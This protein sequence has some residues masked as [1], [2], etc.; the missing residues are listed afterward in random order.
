MRRIC[1]KFALLWNF[2]GRSTSNNNNND[3]FTQLFIEELL[4]NAWLRILT[5]LTRITTIYDPQ[6][7]RN[8][9]SGPITRLAHIQDAFWTE[10]ITYFLVDNSMYYLL[11]VWSHTLLLRLM[12][13]WASC[14]E[15]SMRSLSRFLP[16]LWVFPLSPEL[17]VGVCEALWD[18]TLD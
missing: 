10:L 15:G 1:A 13:S 3:S 14:K 2:N 17:R 9:D 8:K 5:F 11:L 18:R 16:C 7:P 12:H 4:T 6:L